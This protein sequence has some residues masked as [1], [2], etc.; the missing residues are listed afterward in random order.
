MTG[1]ARGRRRY[2]GRVRVEDHYVYRLFVI[3]DDNDKR[4]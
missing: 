3:R 1:K 2:P 4:A